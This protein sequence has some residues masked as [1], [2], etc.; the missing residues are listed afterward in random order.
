MKMAVLTIVVQGGPG[1]KDKTQIAVLPDSIVKIGV[2]ETNAS[3][4]SPNCGVITA[5]GNYTV[6]GTFSDVT[7]IIDAA[8]Q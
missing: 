4:F 1:G 5:N 6:L 8:L 2:G 7:A 3:S